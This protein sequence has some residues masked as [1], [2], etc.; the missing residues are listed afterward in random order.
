MTAAGHAWLAHTL[1]AVLRDAGLN[2]QARAERILRQHGAAGLFAEI[3]AIRSGYVKRLYCEVL[4]DRGPLDSATICRAVRQPGR[5]IMSDYERTTLLLKVSSGHLPDEASRLAYVEASATTRSAYEKRRALSALLAAGGLTPPVWRAVLETARA[6]GSDY[7]KA[8]LVLQAARAQ[9]PATAVVDALVSVVDSMRSDYERHRALSALTRG[10]GLDAP[11]IDRVLEAA[12]HTKS[13]YELAG[14]LI[15]TVDRVP[16]TAAR[17]AFLTVVGMIRSD[18]ERGRVLKAVCHA[19]K[20]SPTAL[21]GVVQA[22]LAMTSDYERAGVLV[23]V[24]ARGPLDD[25]LRAAYRDAV[26]RIH[27]DYYQNQALAALSR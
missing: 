4:L 8:E 18:S 20:P 11:T 5:E 10:G 19:G 3:S 16:D 13:D 27:S 24:A 12:A 26:L 14:L 25:R 2:A 17:P 23:A 7:D 15:E 21:E 9:V 6:I 1:P 22:S